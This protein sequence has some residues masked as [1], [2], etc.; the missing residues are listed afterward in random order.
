MHVVPKKAGVTATTN[1]KG[2]EIQTCLSIKW[3]VCIDYQKLNSATKKDY[4]PLPFI[5]QILDRLVG[6]NYFCFL[7]R[8]SG[9]NQI[10]IHPDDQEKTTFTCPFG[11]FAFRRMPLG[12]CNAPST[13]QWCMMTIFS[14][15]LGDSLEVFTDDF[16]VFGND[17]ESCLAHLRKILEVC[18]RK[19]L[20]M[21][22]GKSHFM[23]RERVVLGHIVSGK[24][25]EVDKAKIEVIQNLPLLGTV[26][27]L[28]SF[29]GHVGFYQRFIQ[30][31][32][33]VSKPL[34]T[35]LCKDKEFI[36][37]EEGKHAFT[38]LKQALIEAPILQSSN[39]DL[40]FEIR[41]DASHYAVGAVLGQRLDKKPTAI[42]YASK[43]LVEAQI[44]YTTTEKELLAVF[45]ALEKFWP[46]ILRS[47]IILYI[48]HAALKYLLSKKEAKP[49]LIRW[50]LLLQEFNLE[51]KD[52]KG[53]ENSVADHL[54]RLHVSG[55]EEIGDTFPDEHLLAILSHALWY[56]HI[57]NFIVTVSI[58]E[59]W[60][61]HQKDKFFHELK[62][63]F[64]EKSLLF[65]LGYD[66]IIGQCIPEEEQ[67]DILV[68]CHSLT[69]GGHFAACK[70]VD[71]ILQN[72]FYWPSIFK[73]AHS[74]YTE[75]IQ[76]QVAINISKWDEMLMWP[77]L[78]VE[79][80]DLCGI[81]FMGP[82]PPSDGKE[83]I[84]V[85]LDYVSKW[86][87][88]IST[89][90]NNHREV[91]R[92]VTRCIFARYGCSRVIISEGGSHFNNAHFQALLKKY[93]VHH[94]V[95]TP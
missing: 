39:W 8:Y 40:P 75:C 67:G 24:E 6:S 95:T 14:D 45:S 87:E 62:Y 11:T 88:A 56:A 7:D 71:K 30:D 80:F 9:Y 52:K 17:F 47:K 55:G 37:D 57:V 21:S 43:T 38:M 58:P 34:T 72:G 22:W 18:I 13:F 48:D 78:E 25:V 15:F 46:Y 92:F 94:R 3:R 44:N 33:K 60:N 42:C 89:R 63:Y 53:S 16:S 19:R 28:R 81:D 66:Q 2:E 54:S 68:M 77:I 84:L 35:L 20:V 70:T 41:Y 59:H 85:A 1:E 4:F 51:I 49:R 93:G 5:D 32:A 86:V 90:T 82:F 26:R 27:D 64:W 12:L 91:L 79:I 29:L 74:F 65:H 73:D 10:A 36:I 61:R 83:Y 76:C 50:V 31:F 69:C 23:V